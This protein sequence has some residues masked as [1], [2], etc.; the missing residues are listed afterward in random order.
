MKNLLNDI[1]RS[2]RLQGMSITLY[3]SVAMKKAAPWWQDELDEKLFIIY[4]DD[5]LKTTHAERI[6]TRGKSLIKW[7]FL[8]EMLLEWDIS[9]EGRLSINIFNAWLSM[10]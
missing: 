9:A 3:A 2:I 10:N 8:T 7:E 4:C 5:S 6:Q 1:C